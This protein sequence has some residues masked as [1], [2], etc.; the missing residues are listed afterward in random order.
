MAAIV[1]IIY[2][3]EWEDGFGARG[4]KLTSTIGDPRVIATTAF[5]GERSDTSVFVHDIVDHRLCGLGIGGHRNEAVA[6]FLHALRSSVSTHSSVA[7]MVEELM[8]GG[9]CGEPLADFLPADLCPRDE[10][11][12]RSNRMIMQTLIDGHGSSA[13][14]ERLIAHYRAIGSAGVLRA[15]SS[16]AS[17]GLGVNRRTAI[18]RCLQ[19]II[20]TAEEQVVAHGIELAQGRIHIDNDACTLTLNDMG[21]LYLPEMRIAVGDDARPAQVTQ[22]PSSIRPTAAPGDP[23]FRTH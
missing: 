1:D 12:T 17:H 8:L 11:E 19:K 21:T 4:W 5:V 2:R 9:D 6:I 15:L 23:I 7:L 18:G 14:Y 10:P 13:V 16:W 22:P 20:Q 3:S